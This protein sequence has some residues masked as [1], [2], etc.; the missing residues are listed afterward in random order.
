MI[1]ISGAGGKTGKA[2]IQRLLQRGAKIRALVHH[3]SQQ[4]DL[5][6]LGVKDV[7]CGDMRQQAFLFQAVENVEAIYHI[8]PN[9][10]PG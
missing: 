1:L 8:C 7:L 3:A 2:I 4:A 6:G 9:M 5:A 10:S